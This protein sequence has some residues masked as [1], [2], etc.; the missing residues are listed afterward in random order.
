[1]HRV[2]NQGGGRCRQ[3][4]ARRWVAA[5]LFVSSICAANAGLAADTNVADVVSAKDTNV[6]D[7]VTSAGEPERPGQWYRLP[8]DMIGLSW[9]HRGVGAEFSLNYGR[10]MGQDWRWLGMG[11]VAGSVSF[12]EPSARYAEVQVGSRLREAF[13]M[14]GAGVAERDGEYWRRQWTASAGVIRYEGQAYMPIFPFARYYWDV[15][16]NAE[17]GWEVGLMLKVPLLYGAAHR[18][19]R[20]QDEYE[21][22]AF[23]WF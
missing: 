20:F 3:A 13:F 16:D 10:R 15:R 1:M 14:L 6:A 8:I 17:S 5:S 11:V 23:G 18:L 9:S 12:A 7:V 19:A 22:G 4:A 21:E 2:H